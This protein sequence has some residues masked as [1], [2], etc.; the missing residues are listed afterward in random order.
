MINNLGFSDNWKKNINKIFNK[1]SNSKNHQISFNSI[2]SGKNLALTECLF[3]DLL[4]Y[5]LASSPISSIHSED[6]VWIA[7]SMYSRLSQTTDNLVVLDNEFPLG[8]IG[9]RE[10]L[11]GVLKNPTPYFFHDVLS[12]E[13]MN[14]KFYIDTRFAKLQ[15]LLEQMKKMK[16]TFAIIQNSKTSFSAISIREILEIGALC[17]TNIKICDLP[18]RKIKVFKRD[19]SIEYLLRS[20]SDEETDLLMLDNE[21]LFIDHTTIIEKITGDLNFLKDV[22][23]FLELNASVFKLAN[24]K[25]IPDK[26]TL[27]EVC[28]M[29]LYMKHPYVM[30]TEQVFTPRDIL[31]A[32]SL[33]L[34]N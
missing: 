19:D 3:D 13:I 18:E 11:K 31:Q 24:P 14:R 29:M 30:T 10:I 8:I 16:R 22:E 9:G 4:P 32:L 20:L 7:C 17:N 23:N 2:N 33:D 1:N 34:L 26:L 5:S 27:S 21:S 15:K 6:N 28:K 12:A 25:L